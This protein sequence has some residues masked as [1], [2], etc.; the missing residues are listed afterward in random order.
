MI[1]NNQEN[2]L[3]FLKSTFDK[4]KFANTHMS[5][6]K[7]EIAFHINTLKLFQMQRC[8]TDVEYISNFCNRTLGSRLLKRRWNIT[9]TNILLEVFRICP[10]N[11]PLLQKT[12]QDKNCQI[13]N[14]FS[15]KCAEYF[16]VPPAQ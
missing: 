5:Y 8:V 1:F 12:N 14:L 15:F 13:E 9:F 7:L 16:L 6:E 11:I 4:S 3:F 10:A 2:L